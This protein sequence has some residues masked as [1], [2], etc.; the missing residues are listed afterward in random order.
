M[1]NRALSICA[2]VLAAGCASPVDKATPPDIARGGDL[3]RTVCIACHTAQVHWREKRLV[4]S[5]DDLIFQVSRWQRVAGQGWSREDINDVAAYL[6]R[7]FYDL[8]CPQ[9]GCG[10]AAIPYFAGASPLP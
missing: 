8:P 3:Y 5:W 7:E 6:N 10:S 1:R 2:L 9:T 4:R